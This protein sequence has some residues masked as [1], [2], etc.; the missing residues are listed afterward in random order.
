MIRVYPLPELLDPEHLGRSTVVVIDVLRASTT[1]THALAAGAKR[2]IPCLDVDEA[3]A[4][5]E[6]AGVDA[7][8]GGERGGLPIAGFDLG[9]SPA[10]Y[11][12]QAVRDRT[13]I[14]TT[15]NGT[16]ALHAAQDARRVLIGSFVNAAAVVD[17]LADTPEVALVC[18]GTRGRITR[19]DVLCAGLFADRLAHRHPHGHFD[20]AA[21]LARDAW[22]HAAASGRTL[23]AELADTQGGRNLAAIDLAADIDDAAHCDQ[24]QLIPEFNPDES[25]ITH[26]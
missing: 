6:S 20:D 15:T 4:L 3:R 10:E 19:E 23:A 1:M 16:R 8:L 12:P 24:F 9:N 22:R 5:R 2:V 25:H 11:T 18:A 17:A 21:H 14:F 13:V 7:L 26:T